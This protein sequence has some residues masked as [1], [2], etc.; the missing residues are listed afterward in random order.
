M[1][2]EE[3]FPKNMVLVQHVIE[4]F[5]NGIEEMFSKIHGLDY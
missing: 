5:K 4:D 1:P 3:C 2:V